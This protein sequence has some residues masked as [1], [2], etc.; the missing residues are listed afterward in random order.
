MGTFCDYTIYFF[1]Y[2]TIGYLLEVAFCSLLEKRL[3]LNR[4][5]LLGPCLPI[6]GLG[7]I[8]IVIVTSPVHNEFGPIFLISIVTCSTLEYFASWA[9]EKLFDIKWWDYS[10]SDSINLNG[11]IC[12]RNSLLFGIGGY[13]IIEYVQPT[14]RYIAASLQPFQPIL[15]ITLLAIF[16]LDLVLSA[17]AAREIGLNPKLKR[18]SIDQPNEIKKLAHLS[19]IRLLTKN[20]T[21]KF[22]HGKI[23]QEPYPPS[24]RTPKS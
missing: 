6:Y 12:L 16:T 10:T 3:I 5:F 4:G 18:L 13:F 21:T 1:I 23:R 7:A 20:I 2:A 19:T 8:L 22:H 9:L 15:S 24:S 14:T 11:R 17:R